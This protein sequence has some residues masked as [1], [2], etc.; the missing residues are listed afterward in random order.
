MGKKTDLGVEE[1][2]AGFLAY[3]LGWVSGL[4][5]YLIEKKNKKVRFHAM[6]SIVFSGAII[7][8]N[9]VLGFIPLI[10]GLLLPIISIGGVIVW[11]VLMVKTYQG[12]MVKLPI[13]GD[14]A[15]QWSGK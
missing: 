4:V 5:V 9:M 7:L 11:I 6:Q 1:N 14:M 12:A 8:A 10:G 2:I 13:V 15:E 3:V